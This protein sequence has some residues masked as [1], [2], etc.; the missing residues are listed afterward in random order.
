M[1]RRADALSAILCG[2][3]LRRTAAANPACQS[4]ELRESPVAFPLNSDD[5][6]FDAE[7]IAQAYAAGFRIAEIA[8]PTRYFAEASSV[9]FRR[10]CQYGL[11]T[12][13]LLVRYWLHRRGLWRQA[14]FR[15]AGSDA[16][17]DLVR[18][19]A[20]DFDPGDSGG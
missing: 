17:L 5:F 14:Q 16:R 2:H 6:L 8:V 4:S 7:I 18:P 9:N 19:I 11:G 20:L 15:R 3:A 1:T 13:A 12:L 10:S